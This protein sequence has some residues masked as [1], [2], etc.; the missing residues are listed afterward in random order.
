MSLVNKI[1][2]KIIDHY[3]KLNQLKDLEIIL[4]QHNKNNLKNKKEKSSLIF[5]CNHI[6]DNYHVFSI[7]KL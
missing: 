6:Y 4:K 3:T 1:V 5:D 7:Y 2:D